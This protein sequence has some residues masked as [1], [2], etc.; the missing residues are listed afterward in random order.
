MRNGKK[1]YNFTDKTHS[2][3]GRIATAMGSIAVV[4]LLFLVVCSI[5]SKGSLGI[6]YGLTAFVDAIVAFSGMVIAVG[7]LKEEDSLKMY[8]WIGVF[9]NASV[10]L[11]FLVLFIIGIVFF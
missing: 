1:S 11:I 5:V 8:P 2:K 6:W 7:S 9:L 4:V 3:D 10:F